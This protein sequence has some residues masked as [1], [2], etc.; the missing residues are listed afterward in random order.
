MG[1][2]YLYRFSNPDEIF[3]Y[4]LRQNGRPALSQWTTTRSPFLRFPT[5]PTV[6]YAVF[7]TGVPA[8]FPFDADSV[9]SY[10]PSEM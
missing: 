3:F 7:V 4:T 10:V 1:V 8:P 5:A 6:M 2:P 9:T